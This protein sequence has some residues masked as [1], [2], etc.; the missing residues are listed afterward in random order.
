MAYCILDMILAAAAT[1]CMSISKWM[2]KILNYKNHPVSKLSLIISALVT[3]IHLFYLENLV[4]L[5]G[6]Q[7]YNI[8]Q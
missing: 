4:T 2:N 1:I 8:Q 3:F 7:I 5:G 6:L